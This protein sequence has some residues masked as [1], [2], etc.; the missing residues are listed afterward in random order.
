MSQIKMYV[1]IHEDKTR[2]DKIESSKQKKRELIN[3]Y[4]SSKENINSNTPKENIIKENNIIDLQSEV[5][6]LKKELKNERKANSDLKNK[7]YDKDKSIQVLNDKYKLYRNKYLELT[8][9]LYLKKSQE[10]HISELQ[11]MVIQLKKE[12]V[13]L[14][15]DKQ[16]E[17]KNINT[18]RE[19][20]DYYQYTI[21]KKPFENMIK[22]LKKQNQKLMI[23]NKEL[24]EKNKELIEINT[25]VRDKYYESQ[26]DFCEFKKKYYNL[27]DFLRYILFTTLIFRNNVQLILKSDFNKEDEGGYTDFVYGITKYDDDWKDYVFI[28]KDKIYLI[29][30]I[31]KISLSNEMQVC[32]Y[33]DDE[34]YAHIV[35]IY[36]K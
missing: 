32:A 6:N 24:F 4:L 3:K 10:D 11:N 16:T 33:I 5:K 12:I 21:F 25:N 22:G 2:K 29:K 14:E 23:L 15:V 26:R 28:H 19:K 7:I 18:F 1:P 34:K 17:I 20:T 35:G 27:G 36:D 8:D 31:R 9:E 30:N 13:L